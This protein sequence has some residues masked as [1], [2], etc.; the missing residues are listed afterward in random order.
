[1]RDFGD[2]RSTTWNH[3]KQVPAEGV[4][5]GKR[6][7]VE[8]LPQQTSAP[9]MP[10]LT[11]TP[12]QRKQVSAET[13]PALTSPAPA[14]TGGRAT[15]QML[16]GGHAVPEQGAI[17]TPHTPERAFDAAVRGGASAVPYAA[18]MERAFGEDFSNV[19]AYVGRR[20]EMAGLGATAAARDEH[21]AFASATPDRETVAHELT[22][23]V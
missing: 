13:I 3:D 19:R 2:K 16:F 5:P 21:V 18:D 23:V 22:H 6:T 11:S 15:L 1:M 17:A 10:A 4:A 14:T 20:A 12:V 9:T 7:L 8:M